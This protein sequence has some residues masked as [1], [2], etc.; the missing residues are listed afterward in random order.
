[1]QQVSIGLGFS[2]DQFQSLGFDLFYF[3]E[4][5]NRLSM[6]L[7]DWYPPV[8]KQKDMASFRSLEE[9]TPV[10]FLEFYNHLV[11]DMQGNCMEMF[12]FDVFF[13]GW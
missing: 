13:V 7:V 3:D 12:P 10:A 1:M 9:M 6:L 5:H 2:I 11:V 4:V 8:S